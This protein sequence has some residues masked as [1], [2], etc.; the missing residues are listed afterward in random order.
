MLRDWDRMVAR[1]DSWLPR[2]WAD[3]IRAQMR[4]ADRTLSG[5]ARGQAMVCVILAILYAAGLTLVGLRSGLVVGVVIGG[6]TFIPYVGTIGGAILS[7]GLAMLQF[8]D[9]LSVGEV[10]LVFAVGHAV[11]GNVLQP[12]LVGDRVGLHPVWVIF[13]LLAG[14][15]LFGF[16]GLLLAIPVAAVIGVL[17]RFA[18]GRYLASPL[19]AG[20]PKPA[21]PPVPAE[22]DPVL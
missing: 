11:E 13:A 9:W 12:L 2:A 7:V 10:A 8:S 21:T 14:G 22:R 20:A 3:T 6:L 1:V 5:F 4:E 18:L 19:Y 15:A 17:A 16:V